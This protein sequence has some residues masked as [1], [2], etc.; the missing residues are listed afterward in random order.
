[1]IF[2]VYRQETNPCLWF[3]C[4]LLLLVNGSIWQR[5]I[6]QLVQQCICKRAYWFF[7]PLLSD[8]NIKVMLK[9]PQPT[10]AKRKEK[11]KKRQKHYPAPSVENNDNGRHYTYVPHAIPIG[12]I[13][14]TNF[15]EVSR[16][17]FWSILYS[18]LKRVFDIG[19]WQCHSKQGCVLVIPLISAVCPCNPT[20][21][22]CNSG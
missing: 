10:W 12:P 7:F 4:N 11:K 22:R 14:S 17:H 19:D 6:F 13:T 21:F 15:P 8:D 16:T 3:E 18:R 20:D 9:V 5:V 1:M 2:L